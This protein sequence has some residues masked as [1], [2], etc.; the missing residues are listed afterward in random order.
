MRTL[1]EPRRVYGRRYK[2]LGTTRQAAMQ[3]L[4]EV[5]IN[6]DNVITGSIDPINLFPDH[7]RQSIHV[8]IGFGT[9]EHLAALSAAY[10]DH[11]FLGAE[12]YHAG[13][14]Y[15]LKRMQAD[16]LSNI[17]IYPDDGLA[18]LQ[19]LKT[20]SID[21]AY[22]LFPDPWPKTHHHKRRFVQTETLTEFARVLCSGGTLLLASDDA[23]LVAWMKRHMAECPDFAPAPNYAHRPQTR[24]AAKALAAGKPLSYLPFM[25]R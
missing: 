15:L 10:P 7:A 12:T 1:V 2:P 21:H 5:A 19:A 20:A 4:P 22:L 3:K 23:P 9:G 17:R 14:S 25:R 8:E 16:N 11:V 18:L 13:V 24:Y 6:L